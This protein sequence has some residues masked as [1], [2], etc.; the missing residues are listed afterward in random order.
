MADLAP[1]DY[2]LFGEMKKPLRGIHFE[3]LQEIKAAL[4]RWIKD[5]SKE[6][7]QQGLKKLVEHWKKCIELNGD[8]VEKRHIDL[9]E[10]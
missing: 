3:T 1:S 8:Y 5:T 2:H 10:Q 9:D 6:F 7:F 4:N